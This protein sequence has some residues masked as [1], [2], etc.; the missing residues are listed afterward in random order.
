MSSATMR[1]FRRPSGTSPRT[2]RCARPS[3]MAVLPTPGSPMST[4]LFFV[5]RAS[6]WIT[7]RISSSRP[8]TGSSLPLRGDLGQVAAV[9]LE[10]L[11]LALGVLVGHAL[12]SADL[13]QRL[14]D[15]VL[16]DARLLEQRRRRAAAG[17]GRE[18]QQQ[19]LGAG[20]F[21]LQPLR[22]L[23]RVTKHGAQPARQAGR[24]PALDVRQLVDQRFHAR[25]HVRG[26]RRSSCRAPPARCRRFVRS[27]RGA[28]ARAG[29]PG[30]RPV[31]RAAAPRG[32]LPGLFRCSDS[33]CPICVPS[34]SLNASIVPAFVRRQ[35]RGDLNVHGRVEIAASP[36][37]CRPSACHARAG[38]T[39][40]PIP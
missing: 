21:V 22:F 5:R 4:G 19:V 16:R 13:R 2:M 26:R 30:A 6:T 8:I 20:E 37:A 18:R 28:G 11:I 38:G 33:E 12:R 34:S 27:G 32:W 3:T 14:Q 24:R 36:R 9:A 40:G 35:C 7:R 1:L 25:R 15:R 39:R 17:L 29:L 10:R 31:R 23:F